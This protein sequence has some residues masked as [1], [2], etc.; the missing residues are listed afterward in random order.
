MTSFFELYLFSSLIIHF[1]DR[2]YKKYPNDC[3]YNL[4]HIYLS[5]SRNPMEAIQEGECGLTKL[6]EFF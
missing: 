2:L 6:V 3:K 5:C 4:F 1:S